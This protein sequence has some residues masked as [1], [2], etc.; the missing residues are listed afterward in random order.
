[1]QE[2]KDITQI[3][4]NAATSLAVLGILATNL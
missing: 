3:I 2:A 1:M 4:V